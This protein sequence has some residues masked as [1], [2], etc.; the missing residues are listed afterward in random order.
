MATDVVNS[1]QFHNLW[2]E[3][4]ILVITGEVDQRVPVS[5]VENRVSA[6]E[7]GGVDVKK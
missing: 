7:K 5:Y 1:E 2:H 3:R 4:P 6:L